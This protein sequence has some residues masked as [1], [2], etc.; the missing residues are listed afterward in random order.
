[1]LKMSKSGDWEKA[2][3]MF[4]YLADNLT[5]EFKEQIQED[6]KY[7]LN[8]YRE[9]IDKQD[10]PW[11]PLSPKTVALKGGSTTIYV[12]T[13]WLKKN[14]SVIRISPAS[15]KYYK[16]F[17]GASHRRRHKPSGLNF[18]QLMLW[19]EYGTDK[20]PP[21]PLIRPTVREVE[22]ELQKRWVKRLN[23]L[24]RRKRGTRRRLVSRVRRR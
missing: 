21:R 10:L 18:N 9:H 5:E 6:A 17:V 8:K 16:V 12:E 1:M 24:F 15:K 14:L 19:L 3:K 20:I 13:G 4:E 11:T 22:P 23:D 2:G 7:V